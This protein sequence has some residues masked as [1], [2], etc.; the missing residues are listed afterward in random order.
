MKK[1]TF[2]ITAA[3]FFLVSSCI[4]SLHSIV[5]E[6]NRVTDDRLIGDWKVADNAKIS[7]TNFSVTSD[8][9]EDQKEGERLL[10]EYIDSIN[11]AKN[12]SIWKFER[13]AKLKFEYSTLPEGTLSWTHESIGG[14]ESTLVK[15]KKVYKN[16]NIIISQQ[17]EL[18]YYLSLI[19][20]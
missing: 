8:D 19:H 17:E 10:K 6:E 20:I 12:Y 1:T 4:P 18:P 15:L 7:V 16:D 14:A 9:K 13:A 3:V 5:N 11:N 2:F